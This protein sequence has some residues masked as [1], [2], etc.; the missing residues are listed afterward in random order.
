LRVSRRS[1]AIGDVVRVIDEVTRATRL[2]AINA[3]IISSEAG[4]QGKGFA[5]VADRVRAMASNTAA[6]TTQI[7]DLV[8]SVQADIRHAVEAVHSGQETVRS[9]EERSR[10]AGVRLQAIIDG[11]GEA[12]KTVQKIAR[13]SRDQASRVGLVVA[14]LTEV[15]EATTR[16]SSA[17]DAQRN[18]QQTLGVALAKVRSVGNDV[19]ASTEY[20]QRDSRAVTAAVRGI[21]GR[22]RGIAQSSDAQSRER[23]RIQDALVVF[24]DTANG[25]VERSRQLGETMRILSERLE[26]LQDHLSAFRVE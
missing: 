15:H 10:E 1:A 6:S 4:D 14:A 5:V 17:A 2:L 11:A 12:E 18:A 7:T 22:L 16:I 8:A 26:Q 13:A 21:I 24:E 20:Q 9:G 23:N 3:S 25:S 19:R